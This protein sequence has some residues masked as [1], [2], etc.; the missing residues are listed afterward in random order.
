MRKSYFVTRN[1]EQTT[2][3]VVDIPEDASSEEIAS[4]VYQASL[5]SEWYYED[6]SGFGYEE[7]ELDT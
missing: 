2:D 6:M 4:I 1:I 7:Q 3:V 5:K